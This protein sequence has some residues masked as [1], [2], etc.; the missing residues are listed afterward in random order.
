MRFLK[1]GPHPLKLQL[2]A[3]PGPHGGNHPVSQKSVAGNGLKKRHVVEFGKAVANARLARDPLHRLECECVAKQ[4]DRKEKLARFPRNGGKRPLDR[5]S[6]AEC[7]TRNLIDRGKAARNR[8]TRREHLDSER[9]TSG[10][11][12]KLSLSR[13]IGPHGHARFTRSFESVRDHLQAGETLAQLLRIA[14]GQVFCGRKLERTDGDDQ[15]LRNPDTTPTCAEHD[16][17]R[18]TVPEVAKKLD[19]LATRLDRRILDVVQK[20]DRGLLK[21]LNN[22]DKS[23]PPLQKRAAYPLAQRF[24]NRFQNADTGDEVSER[25]AKHGE[26]HAVFGQSPNE[27][28]RQSGLADAPQA[29]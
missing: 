22:G 11:L 25:N 5:A 24:Q 9:K 16:Q 29:D 26:R 6:R 8:R 23:I 10:E 27:L 21:R 1:L 3:R 2:L 4:R 17:L 28:Q 19:N 18:A 13:D 7:A 12:Q 14:L 20:Q 15:F